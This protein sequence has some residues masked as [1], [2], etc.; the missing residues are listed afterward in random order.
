MAN[1]NIIFDGVLDDVDIFFVPDEIIERIETIGHE[2]L[3]WVPFATSDDYW[4]IIN[5]KKCVIA[6][7]DG[8]IQW[9]N[10]TYCKKT[11]KAFVVKEHVQYSP[12]YKSIEF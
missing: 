10:S 6:E 9:L 7:T 1:V 8:F 5:G 12:A 4:K 3:T 2:F 11:K